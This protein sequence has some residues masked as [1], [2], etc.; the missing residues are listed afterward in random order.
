VAVKIN[1]QRVHFAGKDRY[2][3]PGPTG[4]QRG[5]AETAS[6]P[7]VIQDHGGRLSFRGI[8]IDPTWKPQD[9]WAV[10]VAPAF[11]QL[12]AAVPPR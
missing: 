12:A 2:G 11:Q 8:Q 10:S 6:G 1:G 9:E 4:S 5:K 3:I 7:I